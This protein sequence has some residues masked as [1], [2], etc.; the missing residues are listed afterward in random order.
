MQTE[1]KVQETKASPIERAMN[2]QKDAI[3][4]VQETMT[5][6]ETILSSVITHPEKSTKEET[7]DQA[8]QTSLET[9]LN[10]MTED[11]SG[12]NTYLLEVQNRIQL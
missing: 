10:D 5:R 1:C 8:A 6:F 4:L 2:R 11:I 7:P 9:R 12:I 3:G